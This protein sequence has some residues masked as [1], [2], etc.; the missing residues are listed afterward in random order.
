M[1]VLIIVQ[2][3][4]PDGVVN[5]VTGFGHTAGA[6][7]S[8]HMDIDMVHK[9]TLSIFLTRVF[10][11]ETIGSL[12]LKRLRSRTMTDNEFSGKFYGIN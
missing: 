12:I 1:V 9:Q 5:V 7:I 6:A 3:G 2:A 4:I 11:N 8:S 10:A